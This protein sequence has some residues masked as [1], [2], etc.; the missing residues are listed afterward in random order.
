VRIG[1]IEVM[2]AGLLSAVIDQLSLQ[3]PR[4]VFKVMQA[5]LIEL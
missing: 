3:C 4:L 2:A 1:S 5:P